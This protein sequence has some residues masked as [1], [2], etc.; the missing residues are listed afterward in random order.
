MEVALSTTFAKDLL[1]SISVSF[2]Q[3]LVL[4]LVFLI[5]SPRITWILNPTSIGT[6]I[7]DLFEII[8][9]QLNL[10]FAKT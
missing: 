7:V 5:D 3:R 9:E 8:V 1:I 10:C 6:V 2:S 4:A